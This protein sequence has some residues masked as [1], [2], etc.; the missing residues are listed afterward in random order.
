M[1]TPES[2]AAEATEIAKLREALSQVKGDLSQVKGDLSQVKGDITDV[3]RRI[4]SIEYV[5]RR[6][7]RIEYVQ[8]P[9]QRH[10]QQLERRQ[11]LVE[12]QQQ[13]LLYCEQCRSLGKPTPAT[14]S[15]VVNV[16]VTVRQP[17]ASLMAPRPVGAS[18]RPVAAG[19]SPQAVALA[20]SPA[21]QQWSGWWSG[22]RS[23]WGLW[24]RWSRWRPLGNLDTGR[25][26]PLVDPVV[27]G[28]VEQLLHVRQPV[29]GAQVHLPPT[30]RV[31]QEAL[32]DDGGDVVAAVPDAQPARDAEARV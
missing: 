5:A 18:E 24:L 12:Q 32:G 28:G 4:T 13:Q 29:P 20:S 2:G 7:T 11:Q 10:Q 3:A 27:G 22:W 15:T 26:A 19:D 8:G 14:R 30:V 21:A 9:L 16:P 23:R 1:A 25:R 6:I 31:A 17:A